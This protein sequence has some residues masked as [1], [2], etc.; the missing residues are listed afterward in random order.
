MILSQY[1]QVSGCVNNV[2]IIF[3]LHA[4]YQHDGLSQRQVYVHLSLSSAL[5][6]QI[7]SS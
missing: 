3:N 1:S 6:H 4:T 5:G 7:H 2:C